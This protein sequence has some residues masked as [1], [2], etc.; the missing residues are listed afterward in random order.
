VGHILIHTYSSQV[1]VPSMDIEQ[2]RYLSNRVIQVLDE[3]LSKQENGRREVDQLLLHT[4]A[5]VGL[6][7]QATFLLPEVSLLARA[8]WL[9]YERVRYVE[10]E[11]LLRRAL[12]GRES[13]LGSEH[14]DT[15]QS[16]NSLAALYQ[17]LGRYEEAQLLLQR[18]L[19]IRER[20]LG[21]EHP[22]TA[23]S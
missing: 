15:I 1:L 18:V 5:C 4:Q 8:G 12:T 9:L 3:L 20:V 19:E 22:D 13:I 17:T 10:A 23:T 7:D 2:Y 6:V 11:L 14:P 21:P 16:M